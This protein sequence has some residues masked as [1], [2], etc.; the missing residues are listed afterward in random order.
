MTQKTTQLKKRQKPQYWHTDNTDS[1]Y[2]PV[3][4]LFF[5]YYLPIIYLLFISIHS[6]HLIVE[7]PSQG[8]SHSEQQVQHS[9]GPDVLS[10]QHK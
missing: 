10:S 2:L 8:A 6:K 7:S 5:T 3:L 4:C 1:F 9:D